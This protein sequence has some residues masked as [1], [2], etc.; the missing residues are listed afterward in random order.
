MLQVYNVLGKDCRYIFTMARS[1]AEALNLE[2][3]N[4]F[5]VFG[6]RNLNKF[7]RLLKKKKRKKKKNRK[8]KTKARAFKYLGK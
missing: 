8:A 2:Q 6:L 7:V 4:R 3:V 5:K 1:S